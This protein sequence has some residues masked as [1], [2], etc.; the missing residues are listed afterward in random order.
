MTNNIK[1][2]T[3]VKVSA[4]NSFRLHDIQYDITEYYTKSQI[5]NNKQ[6]SKMKVLQFKNIVGKNMLHVDVE[7][8]KRGHTMLY[9]NRKMSQSEVDEIYEDFVIEIATKV[10]KQVKGKVYYGF[11]TV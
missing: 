3:L 7:E 2:G 4:T 9:K 6:L 10:A 11:A 1:L 5:L 8:Q